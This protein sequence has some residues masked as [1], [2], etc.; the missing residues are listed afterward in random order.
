MTT[1][2]NINT[3]KKRHSP[4]PAKLAFDKESLLCEVQDLEDG[5]KVDIY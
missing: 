5:S 1:D 3:K 4:D 2:N